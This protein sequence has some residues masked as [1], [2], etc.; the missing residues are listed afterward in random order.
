ME[1]A[2][3]TAATG[4]LGPV[5]AKLGALLGSQYKL[6]HRTRKDVKFIKSKLNSVH[7]IL[8]AIWGKETL[9]AQ[10]KE[11]KKE[12]LDL[13]DDMHDAIDDFILTMEPSHRN[14]HMK[15]QI[16]M[17]ASH[18]QDFRTRVDDVSARCRG[19]WKWEKN[20]CAVS[21]L[22]SRKNATS[23]APSKPPPPRAPFIRKDASELIGMGKW[24]S[25]LIGYMVGG[26]RGEEEPAE[27]EITMVQPQLKLASII[28]M[29]GVGK[30]TLA[31][32]VYEEIGNKFQ[33][34]AFVSLTPT[35]NMKEV[36]TSIL[37]QIGAEPLAGAEAR[38]EEDIIHTISNFLEDKRCA[39]L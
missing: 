3:V 8:W 32:L 22:F 9:D 24:R 11:L 18:F 7:S 38:T 16:K 37:R 27:G 14:K 31:S 21:S 25:D 12:A 34:R 39:N 19:N 15:I 4:S 20:K 36:L 28:G 29:A 5:V 26:G 33:S 13:T 23:S 10:S 30:T 17:Q 1:G 2:P 35:P 6:R